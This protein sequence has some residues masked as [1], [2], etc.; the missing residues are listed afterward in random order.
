M[1]SSIDASTSGAGANAQAGGA[2][3]AGQISI[4]A[5]F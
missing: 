1:A 4:T 5:N 2:G 3:A